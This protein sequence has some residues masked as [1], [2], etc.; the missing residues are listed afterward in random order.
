MEEINAA[1]GIWEIQLFTGVNPLGAIACNDLDVCTL[2]WRQCLTEESENFE[3]VAFMDPYNTVAIHVVDNRD[4][5]K[6]FPVSG[7]IYADPAETMHPCGYIRLQ[8]VMGCLNTVAYGPPVD[9]LI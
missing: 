3:A 2:F 1:Y 7:L 9:I 5:G 8:T 6:T 4:I